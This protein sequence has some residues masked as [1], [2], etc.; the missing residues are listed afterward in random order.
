MLCWDAQRTQISPTRDTNHQR[1]RSGSFRSNKFLVL[2]GSEPHHNFLQAFECNTL[3]DVNNQSMACAILSYVGAFRGHVG[4][5]VPL[6]WYQYVCVHISLIDRRTFIHLLTTLRLF[7]HD[8][9]LPALILLSPG[10]H[11]GLRSKWCNT[12]RIDIQVG[13][14]VIFLDMLEIRRRLDARYI[15]I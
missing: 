14:A 3:A 8:F 11:L 4:L 9:P 12:L 1:V 10:F 6:S 15:P 5:M 7:P 2:S 13:L